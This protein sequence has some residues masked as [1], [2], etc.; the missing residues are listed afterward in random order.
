MTP[1]AEKIINDLASKSRK[2]SPGTLRELGRATSRE[3]ADA[4][5]EDPS[6]AAVLEELRSAEE[7]AARLQKQMGVRE[8]AEDRTRRLK[9]HARLTSKL[10]TI[11]NRE[12]REIGIHAIQTYGT[13]LHNL[14]MATILIS[15]LCVKD[16]DVSRAEADALKAISASIPKMPSPNARFDLSQVL[17]TTTAYDAAK[18]D[19]WAIVNRVVARAEKADR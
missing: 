2:I 16:G 19:A 15:S 1:L 13:A 9:I 17:A 18:N 14:Q 12:A 10:S 4:A 8:S 11:V 7:S 6:I 3:L 5:P